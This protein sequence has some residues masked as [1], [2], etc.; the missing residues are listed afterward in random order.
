MA[1]FY[2]KHLLAQK[3]LVAV[4]IQG[5][6]VLVALVSSV[7]L[8]RL[9]GAEGLGA[10]AFCMGIAQVLV[11]PASL[12]LHQLFVREISADVAAQNWGRIRG[13]LWRGNQSV[14]ICSMMLSFGLVMAGRQF[15][16]GSV[17]RSGFFWVATLLPFLALSRINSSALRGFGN[18]LFSQLSEMTLRPLLFLGL[19]V[20]SFFF[21]G[22]LLPSTAVAFQAISG[23]VVCILTVVFLLKRISPAVTLAKPVYEEKI[24]FKGSFLFITLSGLSTLNS[25]LPV[26]MLGALG[27]KSDAG[28]FQVAYR[29][30]ELIAFGLIAV[31]YIVAPELS[32]LYSQKKSSKLA[33]LIE[34]SGKYPNIYAVIV[35][36]IFILSAEKIILLIYG[37]DF[38]PAVLPFRVLCVAQILNSLFGYSGLILNMIGSEVL[39]LKC[40]LAGFMLNVVLS[41]ILIPGF[42]STGAAIASACGLV[43]WK[44]ITVIIL[45]KKFNIRCG[46]LLWCR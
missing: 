38:I 11:I 13:L 6:N 3:T 22:P 42:G 17:D 15:D 37:P 33:E 5:L 16:A 39:T 35:G 21:G 1:N 29:G 36:T 19:I 46:P 40:L 43:L 20:A 27:L 10:Y 26:L 45:F 24:W 8:A 31:S 23:I 7:L 4:F 14:C 41:A 44:G 34:S 12:G 25:M 18:L 30:S 2:K 28:F 9:L 32:K